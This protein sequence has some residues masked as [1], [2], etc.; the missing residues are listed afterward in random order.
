VK[1]LEN[2]QPH[3][4][5]RAHNIC[6]SKAAAGTLMFAAAQRSAACRVTAQVSGCWHTT[7]VMLLLLLLGEAAAGTA[8][9]HSIGRQTTAA[10]QS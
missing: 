2:S 7:A 8:K 4:P 10:R 5:V 1:A 3:S 6:I 9:D